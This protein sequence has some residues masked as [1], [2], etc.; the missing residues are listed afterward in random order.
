MGLD[1]RC[2]HLLPGLGR[3]AT[4][5]S[6]LRARRSSR[7][8]QLSR[9]G[10]VLGASCD[11]RTDEANSLGSGSTRE[12][13]VQAAGSRACA[14]LV[15]CAHVRCQD[16]QEAAESEAVARGAGKTG[17]RIGR[18]PTDERGT[19]EDGTSVQRLRRTNQAGSV[20]VNALRVTPRDAA[21]RVGPVRG[22]QDY[23]CGGR[24]ARSGTVHNQSPKCN[25]IRSRKWDRTREARPANVQQ[26]VSY[27]SL[28]GIVKLT[29]P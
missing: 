16:G 14:V 8:G 23:D 28:A 10:R 20:T 24:P 15:H 4:R 17:G 9:D 11:E 1:R 12:N 26:V 7:V 6:E 21:R 29:L 18:S 22:G 2:T 5:N 3:S 25:R 13:P 19:P 27:E